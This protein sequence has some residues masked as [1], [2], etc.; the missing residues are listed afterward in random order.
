MVP[1]VIYA[2]L[3]AYHQANGRSQWVVWITLAASMVNAALDAL[4]VHTHKPALGVALAT[5]L[6][7]TGV[8]VYMIA[9][10][11]PLCPWSAKRPR[12]PQQKVQRLMHRLGSQHN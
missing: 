7:W 10:T 11:P 5:L 2:A 4:L 3:T 9:L 6:C 12:R 1:L 8:C